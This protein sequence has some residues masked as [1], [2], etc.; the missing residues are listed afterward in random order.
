M[1]TVCPQGRM[2]SNPILSAWWRHRIKRIPAECF[3]GMRKHLLEGRSYMYK[4]IKCSYSSS[5]GEVP[6]L[7]EGTPLERV[8]VVNSGARVQIPPSPFAGK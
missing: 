1:K 7:A 5:C 8:Q 2:G 3:A 4:L 6:K